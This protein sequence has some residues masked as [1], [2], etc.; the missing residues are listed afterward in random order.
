MSYVFFFLVRH[1]CHPC[2]WSRY[3]VL[4]DVSVKLKPLAKTQNSDFFITIGISVRKYIGVNLVSLYLT[5]CDIDFSYTYIRQEKECFMNAFASDQNGL[6][7]SLIT[8]L[9][10]K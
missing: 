1:V 3:F 9:L 6:A 8:Q 10:L 2:Y 7:L 5:V 4:I